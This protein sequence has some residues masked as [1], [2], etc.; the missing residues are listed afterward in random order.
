MTD[1]RDKYKNLVWID[2]D[3]VAIILGNSKGHMNYFNC[4]DLLNGVIGVQSS[5]TI[6]DIQ[7][8]EIRV[9]NK[10]KYF[11]DKSRVKP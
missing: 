3:G 7:E 4:L 5:L 1:M 8:S 6:K 10:R 2:D 11:I 9:K